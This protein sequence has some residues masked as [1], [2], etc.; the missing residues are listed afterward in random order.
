MIMYSIVRWHSVEDTLPINGGH[1][2]VYDGEIVLEA[3][4]LPSSQIWV[5]PV[6]CY[7]KYHGV[8]YWA[9][10]AR[11]ERFRDARPGKG[12]SWAGVLL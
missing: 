1:F 3:E 6:E 5:D 8:I 11:K 9:D 4:Y 2:L 12:Y 10:Y 7:Q